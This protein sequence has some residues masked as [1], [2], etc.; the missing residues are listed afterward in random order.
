MAESEALR[1]GLVGCGY[2]GAA[3]AQ[4]VVRSDHLRLLGCADPDAAGTGRVAALASGVSTHGSLAELLQ[5]AD[6][7]AVL[8][9][10][11]HDQLA[12]MALSAIRAG[13]HVLVEKPMAMD[14]AQA[15][16]VEFAAASAGVTCMVG[17]SFRYGMARYVADLL[18]R[19]AVGD[20]RAI[21]GS[22]GTPPMNGDWVARSES[23]GG[24]LMYVGCHLIDLALWFVAEEPTSVSATISHRPG[25]GVDDTSALQLEFT[26]HRIAQFL[27][28]QS[29][30][31]FFYEFKVIGRSGSITL[32]GR[33][34]VQF[35]I[36]VQSSALPDWSEP[37]IIRPSMQA[38]HITMMLMPELAE[39]ADAVERGRPPG[40]TASDG[41][42]V[43]RVLDAARESGRT[44][45]ATTLAPMLAAY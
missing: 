6:V 23:G 13:K 1:V 32:R 22:I 39:F 29:A 2:H 38:D 16:E 36:E 33:N 20:L 44:N 4:G 45:R 42:R 11:P 34:F 27:V 43:L 28:T 21:T 41:R 3:L 18:A 7:D 35:E 15:R 19:G 5:T 24:P 25:T 8:I 37:T 31:G 9:A 10:T 40:I 26:D 12:P 17:Y 14:E 30:P